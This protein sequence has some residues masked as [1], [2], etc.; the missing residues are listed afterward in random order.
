MEHYIPNRDF[1][2]Y[3]DRQRQ[4]ILLPTY[5]EI[6]REERQKEIDQKERSDKERE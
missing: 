4:G 6:K 3:R 5:E 1:E 2:A